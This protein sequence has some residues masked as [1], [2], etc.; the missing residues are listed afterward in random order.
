MMKMLLK[1]ILNILLRPQK[2]SDLAL[3]NLA[4]RQQ[5]AIW[6]CQKKRP[7]IRTKDRLFWIIL[8]RFW[9]NWRQ[10]LI[11]VKPETVVRW[12][13]RVNTQVY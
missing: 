2:D 10:A 12:H 6:K 13:K 7:Q 5:L 8:S 4:L 11:V 1:L 3:E 9:S